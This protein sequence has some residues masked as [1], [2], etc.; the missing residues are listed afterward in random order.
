[1]LDITPLVLSL[2]IFSSLDIPRIAERIGTAVIPFMIAV[3]MS[4]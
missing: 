2:S 1:V 3:Y 4:G